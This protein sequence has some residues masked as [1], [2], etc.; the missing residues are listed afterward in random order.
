LKLCNAL[1]D[2][3][4]P[5]LLGYFSFDL[6]KQWNKDTT[7]QHL[8]DE[9]TNQR[10]IISKLNRLDKDNKF[11]PLMKFDHFGEVSSSTM[12]FACNDYYAISFFPFTDKIEHS[13]YFKGSELFVDGKLFRNPEFNWDSWKKIEEFRSLDL[14][15]QQM[16]EAQKLSTANKNKAIKIVVEFENAYGQQK[17]IKDQKEAYNLAKSNGYKKSYRTF[18]R[19]LGDGELFVGSPDYSD[20][21]SYNLYFSRL[22]RSDSDQPNNYP[23]NR[24]AGQNDQDKRLNKIETENIGCI[25]KIDTDKLEQEHEIL[26]T[27]K[28]YLEEWRPS[29]GAK[30]TESEYKE[31]NAA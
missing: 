4:A 23:V 5:V 27:Y 28:E 25:V 29:W 11:H 26:A 3:W 9:K 10:I 15:K 17:T 19:K 7:R 2:K 8:I 24:L 14:C 1:A 6:K 16:R 30:L 18:S 22:T 31:L 20:K 21:K 13:F 12:V